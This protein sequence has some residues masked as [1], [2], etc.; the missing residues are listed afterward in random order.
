[1]VLGEAGDVGVDV[2]I[3]LEPAR[4]SC[5]YER[6][7]RAEDRCPPDAGLL[8]P[9]VLVQL[10]STELSAGCGQGIGDEQSLARHALTGGGEA[11]PCRQGR[12]IHATTLAQ[13][14]LR[15]M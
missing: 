3:K 1:M 7:E 4:D 5:F 8:R 12:S 15:I 2:A 10:L 11:L 13:P 9:E 6:F 14:R